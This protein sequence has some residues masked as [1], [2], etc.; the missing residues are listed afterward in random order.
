VGIGILSLRVEEKSYGH[1]NIL[2]KR[3]PKARKGWCSSSYF[4][5]GDNRKCWTYYKM[6]RGYE[7]SETLRQDI[8]WKIPLGELDVD[9]WTIFNISEQKQE[10]KIWTRIQWSAAVNIFYMTRWIP[11][12]ELIK[13][14]ALCDQ[15]E[16]RHV[17]QGS[18]ISPEYSTY[19]Y[20]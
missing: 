14:S 4:I 11:W 3:L 17:T 5:V 13:I 10:G 8:S 15:K 12:R 2:N 9:R 18:A 16:W 20:A 19:I 7:R 6:L 1:E